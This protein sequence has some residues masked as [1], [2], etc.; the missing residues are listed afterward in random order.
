MSRRQNGHDR[1]FGPEDREY[2]E[3]RRLE[4]LHDAREYVLQVRNYTVDPG[5]SMSNSDRDRALF[6]AVK[7]YIMELEPLFKQAE[8]VG[9]DYFTGTPVGE[10]KIAPFDAVVG[11]Y[12]DHVADRA[13]ARRPV[14]QTVEIASLRAIM[15]IS[16]T[17]TATWRYT[18]RDR[19]NQW[20]KPGAADG[21]G[22]AFD[23]DAS[24]FPGGCGV[25]VSPLPGGDKLKEVT[26]IKQQEIPPQISNCAYRL[27]NEFLAEVG[28]DVELAEL[29]D[30]EAELD[31]SDIE[32]GDFNR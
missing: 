7:S 12:S 23:L 17:R 3:Q 30:T 24:K 21:G 27:C 28:L 8:D 22:T 14:P 6:E 5:I 16:P 19:S 10:F 20:Y 2:S 32:G 4:S 29:T 18:V 11:F 1:E 25:S 13:G 9:D 31:Y 26:F 15:S